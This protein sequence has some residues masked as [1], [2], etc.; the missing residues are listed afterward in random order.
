M[1]TPRLFKIIRTIVDHG[2]GQPVSNE[3]PIPNEIGRLNDSHQEFIDRAQRIFTERGWEKVKSE[4][5]LNG[6]IVLFF[7]IQARHLVYCLPHEMYVPPFEI[8]N[9]WE[10]QGR[11]GAK[12]S[13]VVAPRRFSAAAKDKAWKLGI[14]LWVV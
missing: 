2:P 11:L 14:E 12:S 7:R 9:C 3:L 4:S 6:E 10:A 8:E 1:F 5:T 13:S